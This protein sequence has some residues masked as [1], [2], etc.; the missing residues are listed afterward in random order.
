MNGGHIIKVKQIWYSNNKSILCQSRSPFENCSKVDISK[1]MST[2][3]FTMFNR[4]PL[5]PIENFAGSRGTHDKRSFCN[6]VWFKSPLGVREVKKGKSKEKSWFLKYF[7]VPIGYPKVPFLWFS[8]PEK[9]YLAS[10]QGTQA[11]RERRG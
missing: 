2:H 8:G 5:M 6:F 11:E 7:V 3:W 1:C 4:E 10:V 9:A